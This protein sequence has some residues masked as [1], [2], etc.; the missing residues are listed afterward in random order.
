MVLPPPPAARKVRKQLLADALCALVDESFAK[1]PG[2]RQPGSPIAL[3]D[4]LL[5]AFA[6]FS[7][8]GPSPLVFDR[9][10]SEAY[11]PGRSLTPSRQNLGQEREAL[12]IPAR[13]RPLAAGP[14][15]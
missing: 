15:V 10:R 6:M 14:G 1:I 9:R 13:T 4:A 5:S 12:F 2:H 11:R 8:K 3:P 7:L